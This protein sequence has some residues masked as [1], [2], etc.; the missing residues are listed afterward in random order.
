MKT[1]ATLL[2]LAGAVAAQ[3]TTEKKPLQLTDAQSGELAGFV[4]DKLDAN[5]SAEELDRAIVEKIDALQKG[6]TVEKKEE[7]APAKA[8]GK[9]KRGKKTSKSGSNTQAPE[10]IKNGLTDSDRIVLG[11][12]V[13]T[14]IS[15]D[16]KGEALMDAVKK[17]LARLRDER[18]KASTAETAP[19]KK[20]KKKANN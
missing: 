15:A 18:S 6:T 12:F 9:K 10:T 3:D 5:P 13:V 7:P 16:H 8:K 19:A 11:K 14:E 17:E 1:L 20:K 4:V 2:V